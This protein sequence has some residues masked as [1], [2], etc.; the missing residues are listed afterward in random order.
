MEGASANSSQDYIRLDRSQ[1]RRKLI[2]EI[3]P[4]AHL[5]YFKVKYL[6]FIQNFCIVK[7]PIGNSSIDDFRRRGSPEEWDGELVKVTA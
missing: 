2:I 6:T 1:I 5:K 3:R 4:E 7:L